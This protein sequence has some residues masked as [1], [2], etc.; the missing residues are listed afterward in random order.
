M[1]HACSV[2]ESKC[3]VLWWRKGAFSGMPALLTSSFKGDFFPKN[4]NV[5]LLGIRKFFRGI[6]KISYKKWF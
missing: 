2:N 6:F 4:T 3:T 5:G 1:H